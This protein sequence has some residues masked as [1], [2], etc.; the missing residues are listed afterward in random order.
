[1][2]LEAVA[3]VLLVATSHSPLSRILAQTY[4]VA[5]YL[6]WY[7]S[8][9]WKGSPSKNAVTATYL[10]MSFQTF[11]SVRLNIQWNSAKFGADIPYDTPCYPS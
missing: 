2:F 11:F 1:M 7:N 10:Y 3:A 4:I 6:L 9:V 5:T 8:Q